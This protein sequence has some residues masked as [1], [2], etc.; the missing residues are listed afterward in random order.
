MSELGEA[1]IIVNG[2]KLTIGQSMTMRVALENFSIDL[3]FK[4]LGKDE[5]GQKMTD[6]YKA[7]I[8]EIRKILYQ[9]ELRD[10]N[11]PDNRRIIK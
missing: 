10:E 9:G 4:G 6:A 2:H 11:I 5:H 3:Q 7:R 1:L 8:R